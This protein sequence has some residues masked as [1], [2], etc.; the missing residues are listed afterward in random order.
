MTYLVSFLD[1]ASRVIP[2]GEFYFDEKLPRLEN[3][4]K[5]AVV[6]RGIPEML[7]VE[8]P[9]LASEGRRIPCGLMRPAPWESP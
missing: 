8:T 5:K 3:T 9:P 2:H 4:L 1:D 7:Y 6:R